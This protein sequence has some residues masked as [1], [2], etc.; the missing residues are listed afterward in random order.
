MA[1]QR[2]ALKVGRVGIVSSFM[3]PEGIGRKGKNLRVEGTSSTA[4]NRHGKAWT[5]RDDRALLHNEAM[6]SDQSW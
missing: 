6:Q 3:W 5:G 2:S 4:S 1:P